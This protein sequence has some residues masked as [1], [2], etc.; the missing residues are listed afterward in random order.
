M[1]TTLEIEPGTQGGQSEANKQEAVSKW[2]NDNKLLPISLVN[3]K[4]TKVFL[5]QAAMG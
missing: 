4:Q 2:L 5:D 3:G 1:V